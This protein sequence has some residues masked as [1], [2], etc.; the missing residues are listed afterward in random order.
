M[1]GHINFPQR[2]GVD[3]VSWREVNVDNQCWSHKGEYLG[4]CIK[5]SSSGAIHD[6]DPSFRFEATGNKT[7]SGLDL[8]FTRVPCTSRDRL[9][10]LELHEM[11]N[12]Q[13]ASSI[14]KAHRVFRNP[15][16]IKEI[17]SYSDSL[18]EYKP[19]P[20]AAETSPAATTVATTEYFTPIVLNNEYGKIYEC[21][22]CHNKTGTQVPKNPEKYADLFPHTFVCSNKKKIPKENPAGGRK[23]KK[24][25][26]KRKRHSKKRKHS[27]SKKYY[28][29]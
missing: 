28:K 21:P 14:S 19:P 25:S 4:R 6:Q 2:K 1:D 20:P 11:S 29:R 8:T 12:N 24:K 16:W 7:F 10:I 22:V 13:D 27:K 18:P 17:A 3:K 23:Y 5:Q 15:D 9:A 26:I